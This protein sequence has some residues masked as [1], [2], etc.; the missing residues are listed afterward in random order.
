[1]TIARL[2]IGLILLTIG[3]S[4]ITGFSILR[5]VI[6]LLVIYIGFRIIIGKGSWGFDGTKTE[7]NADVMNEVIIFGPLNRVVGSP[8]FRGGKLT[9]ILGGGEIDLRGAKMSGERIPIEVTVILGGVKFI[10][11]SD[12]KVDSHGT[13]ILGGFNNKTVQGDGGLL[14]LTG[15][16]ILGGVDVRN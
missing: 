2:I 12:W 6:A 3:I 5:F 4:I 8:N 15:V 14:E 16:V 11:P 7:S 10:V 9:V 13:A 1:M